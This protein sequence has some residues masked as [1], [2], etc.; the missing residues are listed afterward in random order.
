M[1]QRVEVILIDDVDESAADETVRF[2]LDGINYEIDLS[3]DNAQKLRNVLQP[4]LSAARRTSGRR[5]RGT[6]ARATNNRATAIR[7][8]AQANG[9]E[10]SPRGRVPANIIEAYDKAN[11]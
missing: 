7:E 5:T 4:Y 9:Y 3:S 2:G 1:A 6:G 10:V 8:W 11:A